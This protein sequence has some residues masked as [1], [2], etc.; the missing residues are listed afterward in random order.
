GA[1]AAAGIETPNHGAISFDATLFPSEG[2]SIVTVR[3]RG[4][5]VD[6]GWL[7]NN[8]VGLLAPQLLDVMRGNTR[9]FVPSVVV[10]GAQ[11]E[12]LGREG[13]QWQASAGEPGILVGYPILG[14][15]NQ[16]G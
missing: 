10:R 7:V 13:L 6:G 5:P 15:R 11:T 14:F 1:T 8:E 2:S 12:W 4:L 16:G 3:Q 9:V